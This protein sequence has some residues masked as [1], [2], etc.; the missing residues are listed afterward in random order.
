MRRSK[1]EILDLFFKDIHASWQKDI[2][3]LVTIFDEERFE[4]G[5]Q[6][7]NDRGELYLIVNG[8]FGKYEKTCPVR[9]AIAG[10]PLMIPIQKHS[11]HF[12]AITQGNTLRT[13]LSQFME[14]NDHNPRVFFLYAKM[15]ARQQQYLDYRHK[16]LSLHNQDK[17]DFLLDKYPD[18]RQH[19]LH[20]ELAQFMGI[21][22]ELLRRIIRERESL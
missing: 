22:E 16:L 5:E 10:E 3:E 6:M 7:I 20:K 15:M 11:Y 4:Q 8:I 18:L 17:Y 12:V 14:I 13:S 19:I 1:T 21:S 9:Y 2:P